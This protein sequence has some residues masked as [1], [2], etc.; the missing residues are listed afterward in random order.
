MP[1]IVP[2]DSP[3]TKILSSLLAATRSTK[4]F[5]AKLTEMVTADCSRTQYS[6]SRPIVLI[7]IKSGNKQ[8]LYSHNFF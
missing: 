7:R 5:G 1:Q 6:K 3:I 4:I 2:C 8:A